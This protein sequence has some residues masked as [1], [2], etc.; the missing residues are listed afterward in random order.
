[1]KETR[2]RKHSFSQQDF[3]QKLGLD[4]DHVLAIKNVSMPTHGIGGK[5]PR[6]INVK[7]HILV[8]EEVS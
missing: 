8:E 2:I 1:M 7:L 3:L 4:G 5:A 6:S